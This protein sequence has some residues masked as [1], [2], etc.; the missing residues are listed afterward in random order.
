MGWPGLVVAVAVAL[1][2][3][4]VS[5]Q[6]TSCITVTDAIFA[7]GDYTFAAGGESCRSTYA[8][9]TIEFNAVVVSATVDVDDGETA[10]S[11]NSVVFVVPDLG[12]NPAYFI[13]ELDTCGEIEGTDIIANWAYADAEGNTP[14]ETAFEDTG[15]VPAI[16]SECVLMQVHFSSTLP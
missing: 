13:V 10:F 7:A 3:G 11:D 16:C 8:V 2:L 1:L 12:A 15:V 4:T 5:A 14:E 9:I 6:R